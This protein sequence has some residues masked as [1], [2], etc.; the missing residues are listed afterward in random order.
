LY[1]SGGRDALV[2]LIGLVENRL[3][4]DLTQGNNENQS[5]SEA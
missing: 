3:R 2:G 1:R 4:V 5:P